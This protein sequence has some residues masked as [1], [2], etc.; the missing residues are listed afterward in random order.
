VVCEHVL[1]HEPLTDSGLQ[2]TAVDW[3]ATGAVVYVAY[4]RWASSHSVGIT[5]QR[6]PQL[7]FSN[8]AVGWLVCLGLLWRAVKCAQPPL[9]WLQQG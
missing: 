4:G 6:N 3:N 7:S 9:S 2:C 1:Q 8:C 5:P